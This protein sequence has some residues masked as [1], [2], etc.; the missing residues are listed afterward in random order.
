VD[1]KTALGRIPP[2]VFDKILF[3]NFNNV[4]NSATSIKDLREQ[5]TVTEGELQAL[6]KAR[7]LS[8]EDA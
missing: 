7:K 3:V 2:A 6:V 4:T 1:I 5:F 8:P